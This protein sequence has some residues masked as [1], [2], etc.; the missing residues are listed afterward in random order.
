MRRAS[1]FLSQGRRQGGQWGAS[2]QPSAPTYL[3]TWVTLS[4]AAAQC[5]LIH[6]CFWQVE[7]WSWISLIF[8]FGLDMSAATH[9][10]RA[11]SCRLCKSF[12]LIIV[13]G[14]STAASSPWYTHVKN[15]PKALT[16][17]VC[18]RRVCRQI[19]DS[20]ASHSKMQHTWSSS[21][22]TCEGIHAPPLVAF[23][24]VW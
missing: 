1:S 19:A 2:P 20:E 23:G 15:G 11:G 18:R 24:M 16:A 14:V 10:R 13:K 21:S 17:E 9:C 22:K 5:Q 8:V 6:C 3:P 7:A 12:S 4:G